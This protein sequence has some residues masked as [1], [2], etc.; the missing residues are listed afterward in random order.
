MVP[1]RMRLL[2]IAIV[3]AMLVSLGAPLCA[4]ALA[5][6]VMANQ[7]DCAKTTEVKAGCCLEQG[8][9]TDEATPATG[10]TQVAQPVA[11]ATRVTSPPAA[12][13]RLL[14]YVS[15]ATTALR[16]SPPDLVTLFGTFLI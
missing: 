8:D 9:C 11:D 1:V 13:S 6:R 15:A 5:H 3:A 7:H 2:V 16:S 14:R 12:L 10:K 4:N